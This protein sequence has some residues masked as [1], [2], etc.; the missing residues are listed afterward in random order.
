MRTVSQSVSARSRSRP[1]VGVRLVG[2]RSVHCNAAT[3]RGA[4]MLQL[5]W[6]A[7]RAGDR[8]L[9]HD[10]LN[11]GLAPSEG[12]VTFVTTRSHQPND[13]AIRIL[14]SGKVV[15]PRRHAVHLMPLDPRMPC[16]RCDARG[17]DINAVAA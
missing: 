6:N 14:T 3:K 11:L 4:L 9:V 5:Q 2:V 13:I 12:L 16:W 1:S 8:V 17:Y 10:D 7:L 15:T